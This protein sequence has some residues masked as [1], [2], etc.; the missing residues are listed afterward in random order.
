MSEPM[1]QATRQRWFICGLLFFAAAINY[2]DRQ[3]IAL[4]KP[5]LQVRL[6]WS[7]IG[8]LFALLLV[9]LL[10]PRISPITLEG[11]RA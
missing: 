7:E 11:S 1:S 4:L 10:A 3:V 6:G 9:Q 2:M 5:A 8:Y